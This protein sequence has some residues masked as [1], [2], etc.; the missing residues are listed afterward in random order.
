VRHPRS[1][2]RALKPRTHALGGS[3]KEELE[4][5]NY[6]KLL[7]GVPH[8]DRQPDSANE[9]LLADAP[10]I[11]Y[12][13]TRAALVISGAGFFISIVSPYLAWIAASLGW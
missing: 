11:T 9:T 3:R 4:T 1:N 5:A 6:A 12:R 13:L 10:P 7:P 8:E 2:A